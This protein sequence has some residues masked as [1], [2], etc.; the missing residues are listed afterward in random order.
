MKDKNTKLE[1]EAPQ[2]NLTGF[3][4]L[5]AVDKNKIRV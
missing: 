1:K 2:R 4:V 5:G 3:F